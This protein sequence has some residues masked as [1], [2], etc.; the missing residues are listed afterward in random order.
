[1]TNTHTE[2]YEPSRT[3]QAK[4]RRR[5]IQ[6]R[7]ASPLTASPKRAIVSFSFDDFPKSAAVD[8]SSII[9]SVG[10][11]AC[12]YACTGLMGT[13]TDTGEMFDERNILEL[14]AAGHEIGA[15]TDDHLDCAIAETNDV[16]KSINSNINMLQQIGLNTPPKHFAYPYGETN[17][18][19]KSALAGRFLTA[20]GVLPG[21]NGKGSDAMQLRAFELDRDDWSVTRAAEA[22]EAAARAPVWINIF[23]HDVCRAPSAYGTTPTALRR[24]ARLARDSGAAILTP[25]EAMA[26]IERN[27]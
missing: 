13:T 8:G 14:V 20:R 26:E 15:H 4:I 17:Q 12:F 25:S 6:W 11:R 10:G 9:E 24:L 7:A 19:I 5:M 23:T 22:I 2:T 3:F 18:D 16:L 1:M 27:T 21:T